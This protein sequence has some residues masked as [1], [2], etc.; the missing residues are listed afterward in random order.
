MRLELRVPRLPAV[1]MWL[2][3][4][5]LVLFPK[6]GFRVL[7][8]PLTWGYMMLGLLTPVLLV[9]RALTAP[10]LRQSRLAVVA[11]LS[12][13]PF[14]VI[15]CYSVAA[16][17]VENVGYAFAV[18]TCFLLLP[19]LFLVVFPPY[20]A[21]LNLLRFERHFRFCILAAAL[22][23]IFLF[24]YHPIMGKF[25][26]IPY[27]TVNAGDYGLLETYK[28]IDRGGY[29]KLISTYNNGNLYG[30]AT[31][32]LLPLYTLLEPAAWKRN[33]VRV[34]LALTLSRT[35]WAGLML[36]Q[37]FSLAAQAPS[38]LG[39]LPRVRP[40][41][42]VRRAVALAATGGLV[43][44]GLFFTSNNLAFIYAGG[45]G[46]REGEIGRFVN[47]P[48]MPV[49]P[50]TAFAELMYASA[51]ANYGIAGFFSFLLIF[52]MPIV[53]IAWKPHILRVPS[54]RA[55]VKGLL[56]YAFVGAID[57]A[58]ILIPV[59]AFYWFA[60]MTMLFG[61]PGEQ[62]LQER[63]PSASTACR[64]IKL[65]GARRS[66]S[67]RMSGSSRSGRWTLPLLSERIASGWGLKPFRPT[68][69]GKAS[70]PHEHCQDWQQTGRHGTALLRD[71]RDR[72]Q[73]QWRCGS[74][75]APHQ[76]CRRCRM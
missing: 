28:H 2:L 14:Q 3:V 21:R 1:I 44:V 34:A 72:D 46:G 9:V 23:G 8:I 7:N 66:R 16:N 69:Q 75:Q 49:V 54:R 38:L 30:V 67:G 36:E 57:G 47:P 51:L 48:L 53:L 71:R 45:L 25:I 76:R 31:L 40:G 29:L 37:V 63:G 68:L 18:A 41:P 64:D 22:W 55:A 11:T 6:G 20:L 56:L 35:V 59:M 32:I 42:A 74:G 43:L 5:F 17:G 60:Y 26:E 4:T 12:L 52:L 65:A 27:L 50:V 24:F 62:M 70:S 19:T 73:S 15:L 10:L 13:V 39:S 61:L 33:T 58:T